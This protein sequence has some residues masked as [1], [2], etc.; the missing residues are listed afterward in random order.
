MNRRRFA[1]LSALTLAATQLPARAQAAATTRRVGIAPVGLGSISGVFMRRVQ[2][3]TNATI[4]GLVTGHPVEKGAKFGAMYNVPSASIY[5]YENY[6]R[7]RDNKAIEAVYI[8]LPNSMHCEYVVRAAEAGKHV[9]CEKPMGIS[10][11]ECRRMIEA[12]RHAGVTLM[13]GYR[14]QYDAMFSH[15]RDLI[16]AGDIGDILSFQ[17]GDSSQ[18]QAGIWRLDP[19]LSGGGSLFDTGIYQLNTIR[20][21]SGED[22][23]D[24]R[25]FVSTRDPKDPRF[26]KV[27]QTISWMMKF[28]SGVTA[29]CSSSHGQSGPAF[30]NINGSTGH[31]QI[32]PTFRYGNITYAYKGVTAKGEIS[33]SGNATNPDQFTLEAEHFADCILN[34]KTPATGG[35]EGLA[36]LLAIE[37]IYKAA[38]KPVA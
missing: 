28:P 12:C 29:S 35:E 26:A 30:L 6:D 17:A 9:F 8:G 24:F 2:Q 10:S 33:G 18:K 38:G 13:V 3:T 20:W 25:A 4:A 23:S 16:R 5:T 32:D 34:K 37:A 36:D 31:V 14:M 7:I 22:P 27:E 1:Q 21:L 15:I 19:A 11:A